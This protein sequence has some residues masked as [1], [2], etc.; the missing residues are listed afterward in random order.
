MTGRETSSGS[1][2]QA[3]TESIDAVDDRVDAEQLGLEL[4]GDLLQLSVSLRQLLAQLLGIIHVDA[5]QGLA[6]PSWRGG[7]GNGVVRSLRFPKS[8]SP[9]SM[10]AGLCLPR[11]LRPY[12]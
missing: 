9:G 8:K 3:R 6:P 2:Y 10:A 11:G 5:A 12:L 4:G 7:R 1:M